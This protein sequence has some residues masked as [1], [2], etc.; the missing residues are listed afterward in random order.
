MRLICV[1]RGCLGE[2][3]RNKL[4]QEIEVAIIKM[5]SN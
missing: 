4:E 1:K 2:I 3:C 5:S